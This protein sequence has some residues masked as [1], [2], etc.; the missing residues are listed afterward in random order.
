MRDA[1]CDLVLDVLERG[2]VQT[3]AELAQVT[4][5]TPQALGSILGELVEEGLVVALEPSVN[6]RGRPSAAYR[7]DADAGFWIGASVQWRGVLLAL[8]DA[9]GEIRARAS[10]RHD[11]SSMGSLLAEVADKAKELVA[12]VEPA[13]ERLCAAG[14]SVQG[15]VDPVTGLVVNSAAWP[16]RDVD[17]RSVFHGLTGWPTRFDSAAQ[18][19]ARA[20]ARR[21]AEIR[22]VVAVLYFSHDPYLV[23][24]HRGEVLAGRHGT[25][26]ELAHLPIP[27][28]T[29]QCVCGR[30][31]CVATVVSA[32]SLVDRYVRESGRAAR[33]APDVIEAA[34]IGDD[35]A[36][37]A[38][39]E[40]GHVAAQM[41]ALL[42]PYIDPSI[43]IVSGLVGGPDSRGAQ[44]LADQI[45]AGL[46][47]DHADLDVVISPLG[48]DAHTWGA[49]T[50]ARQERGLRDADP[51]AVGS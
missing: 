5:L 20:E 23:L 32:S 16:D 24:V 45:R 10:F 43:L 8:A 26:G 6:G 40:F 11:G 47:G 17:A 25:G 3:R 7:V 51:V 33:A 48:R 35:D 15:L 18:A 49:L 34:R 44:H 39:D 41:T 21:V 27:G 42:V 50:L 38:L 37:A 28:A 12:S 29:G 36:K 9:A 22:G 2:G 4:S 13:A 30:V 46:R 31:G 1:N 19:T 14:L